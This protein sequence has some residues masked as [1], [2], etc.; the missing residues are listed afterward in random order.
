MF[1]SECSLSKIIS[2]LQKMELTPENLVDELCDKIDRW[3]ANIQAFIPELDRRERLHKDVKELYKQFPN[4]DSRPVMFGI[5]VGIKEIFHVDGFPT[6]AGS[7]LP[8]EVLKGKEATVVSKLKKAGALILGKTV[9]TEF[10]YFHPGATCNPNNFEHTPGGS[11]SGS[12]AAVA[13][14]FCPLALGTQTIGSISRPAAYCGV[15][16]FKPSFGRIPTSG[17]IP[18]SPSADHVGFFTQDIKGSQIISSVLCD[19]WN[20][21][22]SISEKLPILGIPSGNYLKQA[23]IDILISF[24]KTINKLKNAGFQVKTTSAFTN[25]DEINFLHREM[26]SYEFTQVHESWYSSFKT[27]YSQASIDLI[28]KG[29]VVSPDKFMKTKSGREVLRNKLKK[30][31][32]ENEIDLWIS[33]SATSTAPKGLKSTGDP[34][35]NLPWTYAGVPTLSIPFGMLDGMP[36]GIQFARNFGEDESLFYLVNQILKKCGI[37]NINS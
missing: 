28:K 31:S 18:F 11:S 14:G 35:M 34:A 16:G 32:S 24:D 19:N 23:S 33:P 8:S 3:D 2:Q 26:I 12:A 25:I 30:L 17:V 37:R 22:A 13:S 10:A 20:A 4:P 6:K 7:D 15:I 1:I 5:P 29:R 9:T 21:E 27:K 36:Y